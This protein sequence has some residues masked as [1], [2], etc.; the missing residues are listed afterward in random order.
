MSAASELLKLPSKSAIAFKPRLPEV[1]Q[2][3]GHYETPHSP[4]YKLYQQSGDKRKFSKWLTINGIETGS[5]LGKNIIMGSTPTKFIVTVKYADFKRASMMYKNNYFISC[6]APQ[7]REHHNI[8]QYLSLWPQLGML[9]VPDAAG[10]VKSR[11]FFWVGKWK[12]PDMTEAA[13]V[14]IPMRF[15]G[16]DNLS[17]CFDTVAKQHNIP[18]VS[19]DR[20][21]SMYGFNSPLAVLINLSRGVSNTY[22]DTTYNYRGEFYQPT[23]L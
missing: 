9:Y 19:D 3:A 7:G 5:L 11:A 10:H 12:N 14:I 22:L 21:S 15:Y 17:V 23:Q 6:M 13:N 18:I 8:Q 4:L 2:L 16:D 1:R 20:A